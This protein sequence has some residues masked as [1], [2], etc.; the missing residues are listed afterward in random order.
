MKKKMIIVLAMIVVAVLAFGACG[1][2]TPAPT[3]A[4]EQ[5]GGTPAP[6]PEQGDDFAATPD[7]TLIMTNNDP[8]T[9]LAGQC[10]EAWA[11]MV[12]EKSKGR[13]KIDI[14][15]GGALAKQTEDF[16]KVRDGSI[17]L[18]WGLISFYPGQFPISDG[19]SLPFLPYKS[20]AQASEILMNIWENTDLL[21]EEFQDVHLIMLRTNC[22][23]PIVTGKKK[24]ETTA[25]LKGMTIRATAAPMVS[26]LEAFGAGGQGCPIGELFQNLQQG[27]F[28][29]ALTDW[30]AINS[31]ALYEAAQY[32]A[33]EEVQY[34]TYYLILNKGVYERLAPDLQAIL[35]DCSGMAAL[36]VMKDAW[37][38]MATTA[39]QTATEQGC[40][41]YKMPDAEHQKLVDAAT[42]V[43]QD[44][45]AAN[46]AS[47]QALYDKIVELAG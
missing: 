19:L 10:S 1:N 44:W 6:A 42:K 24:L 33:D 21:T 38:D 13:I 27:T 37:D 28:D 11:A 32:Y 41:V 22:N 34:N 12:Y 9:S 39:K 8:A 20:A 46:G 4:P 35:D 25:D 14:T 2:N 36:N 23:A 15:H 31:F 18:S 45:I 30:H 43:Q 7:V 40:D 29:G 5:G 26:W 16:N 3:P 17:D 47:G